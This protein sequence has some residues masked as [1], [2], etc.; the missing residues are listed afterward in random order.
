[1]DRIKKRFNLQDAENI[2]HQRMENIKTED[3]T[4][5]EYSRLYRKLTDIEILLDR[6]ENG[7]YR[8]GMFD[9]EF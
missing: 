5:G 4:D 9:E 8:K 2:I 6:I 1:M 3:L 7:Y